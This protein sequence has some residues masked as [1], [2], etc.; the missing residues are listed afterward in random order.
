M[1]TKE[2][3]API[4]K[5]NE[6]ITNGV[7]RIEITNLMDIYHSE[8]DYV[9]F[10]MNY[11]LNRARHN[12]NNADDNEWKSKEFACDSVKADK[13]F[14]LK[15]PLFF[16][17]YTLE[18]NLTA[19]AIIIKV[20][21]N[22]FTC[23]QTSPQ[24]VNYKT[25]IPSVLIDP[26]LKKNDFITYADD[27]D[28][29]FK[30]ATILDISNNDQ[31][32][33]KLHSSNNI[34]TVDLSK[35]SRER[36]DTQF[37][38][39]INEKDIILMESVLNIVDK[40]KKLVFQSIYESFNDILFD[41]FGAEC[42]LDKQLEYRSDLIATYVHQF[43]FAADFRYRIECLLGNTM[44][45]MVTPWN[46]VIQ[47]TIIQ[48]N[49]DSDANVIAEFPSEQF[50][51]NGRYTCDICNIEIDWF[52]YVYACNC[53]VSDIFGEDHVFCIACIYSVIIQYKQLKPFLCELLKQVINDDCIEQIVAF[54]VGRIVECETQ[55]CNDEESWSAYSKR[56]LNVNDN[57]LECKKR[58]LC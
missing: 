3:P 1:T 53:E 21:E 7:I 4:L 29:T 46:D 11:Q 48:N 20:D 18:Y 33:I 49:D 42:I 13:T 30:H 44:L 55:N 45:Y 15:V 35:I 14:N 32:K 47:S 2:I 56:C 58:K 34:L 41:I 23:E 40:Q 25:D 31:V 50:L 17:P 9:V 38:I 12:N 36:F 8:V 37:I 39:D 54:C 28:M 19:R 6:N 22:D 51:D 52:E 43:L 10:T 5:Y 57:G 26:I 16:L 24:S 27:S